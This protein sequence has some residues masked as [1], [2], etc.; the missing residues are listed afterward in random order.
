MGFS[1]RW[2]VGFELSFNLNF[3]FT[4]FLL[5][6]TCSDSVCLYS[7]LIYSSSYGNKQMH[8]SGRIDHYFGA[9][10]LLINTRNVVT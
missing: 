6:Y 3:F 5:S 9:Q 7:I 2:S 8:V 10:M 1:S 4:I